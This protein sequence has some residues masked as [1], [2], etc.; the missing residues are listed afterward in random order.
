MSYTYLVSLSMRVLRL[1]KTSTLSCK[2]GKPQ[3]LNLNV[4]RGTGVESFFHPSKRARLAAKSMCYSQWLAALTSWTLPIGNP[5]QS[6]LLEH[7]YG[8]NQLADL[9]KMSDSNTIPLYDFKMQP[10]LFSRGGRQHYSR[11][12]CGI[13][14][15]PSGIDKLISDQ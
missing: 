8:V 15:R 9:A 6:P 11:K 2:T 1:H 10:F 14:P 7:R 3:R 5:S 13:P 4:P 12:G